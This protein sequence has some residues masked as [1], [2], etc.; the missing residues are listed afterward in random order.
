MANPAIETISPVILGVTKKM[1]EKSQKLMDSASG[2]LL[3]ELLIGSITATAAV[4]AGV[5]IAQQSFDYRLA[6]VESLA[7]KANDIPLIWRDIEHLQKQQAATHEM[8]SNHTQRGAHPLADS[9]IER[10]EK[11]MDK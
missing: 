9:R 8:W 6:Q 3:M 7:A 2:R 5:F 10:L 4:V 1:A 11:R